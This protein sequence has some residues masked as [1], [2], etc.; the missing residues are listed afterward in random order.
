V[1]LESVRFVQFGW[2]LPEAMQWLRLYYLNFD[3]YRILSAVL[4]VASFVTA[5][6]PAWLLH[7]MVPSGMFWALISVNLIMA[8]V[9]LALPWYCF[10]HGQLA[11]PVCSI[12]SSI[13]LN[14]SAGVSM[15][16]FS[17]MV[18][19]TSDSLIIKAPH[20]RYEGVHILLSVAGI[21]MTSSLVYFLLCN[22]Y[23][24]ESGNV[25]R[26]VRR[27]QKMS[28]LEPHAK[29]VTVHDFGMAPTGDCA[30]C[31]EDL[32]LLPADRAYAPPGCKDLSGRGLLRL[33]CDHMFHGSCADRWLNREFGCPVC[34]VACLKMHKCT[35]YCLA[36]P[37]PEAGTDARNYRVASE[38]ENIARSGSLNKTTNLGHGRLEGI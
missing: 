21:S 16:I 38:E 9:G 29:L 15:V 20:L 36:G 23:L 32:A 10:R 11:G 12:C 25:F 33:P 8:P 31:L 14:L 18:S 3:S 5:L 28:A 27:M 22:F 13:V 35:R 26:L 6:I 1:R 7:A 37:G 24:Q 2:R 30:I 19:T 4:I 34:R 17:T